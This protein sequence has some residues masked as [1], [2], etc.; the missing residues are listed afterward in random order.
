MCLFIFLTLATLLIVLTTDAY[1]YP[2]TKPFTP[3]E[4]TQETAVFWS[5]TQNLYNPALTLQ[6]QAQMIVSGFIAR[7]IVHQEFYHPG[8]G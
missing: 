7:T 5:S 4:G 8:Y 3:E 2:S 1:A 6:T